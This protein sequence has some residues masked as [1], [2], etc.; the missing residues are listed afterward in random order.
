MSKL[1]KRQRAALA[2]CVE[3]NGCE[4]ERS[5]RPV[6][7]YLAACGMIDLGPMRG[8]GNAWCRA[9]PT[10]KGV[11]EIRGEAPPAKP[12][13]ATPNDSATA[14]AMIKR[15][16]WWCRAK[17]FIALNAARR[18]GVLEECL[19]E[20]DGLSGEMIQKIV[21]HLHTHWDGE[22]KPGAKP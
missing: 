19:E 14:L 7:D 13:P 18:V 11:L 9:T 21:R 3:T 2:A 10:V 20:V 6:F 15:P 4:V 5:D 16:A 17:L 22:Y 8:P 12:T 1:T